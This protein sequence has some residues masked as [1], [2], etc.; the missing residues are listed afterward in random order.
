MAAPVSETELQLAFKTE[1]PD[2]QEIIAKALVLDPTEGSQLIESLNRVIHIRLWM[3]YARDVGVTRSGYA[4][5]YNL[6]STAFSRFLNMSRGNPASK[7]AISATIFRY[8][9]EPYQLR[10]VLDP[11]SGFLHVYRQIDN[12]RVSVWQNIGSR[13]IKDFLDQLI[14]VERT[15]D[16]LIA[17]DF[18]STTDEGV[19]QLLSI[20]DPGTVVIFFLHSGLMA[21][22][23]KLTQDVEVVIPMGVLLSLTNVKDA[24][25][26]EMTYRL[27]TWNQYFS[28]SVAFII[29]SRSDFIGE[30]VVRLRVDGRTIR[31]VGRPGEI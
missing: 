12:F 25:D 27:S 26:V 21:R 19:T 5:E 20:R 4:K 18:D 17:V 31:C 3:A 30:L 9:K 2:T 29:V 8:L 22:Y 23:Q 16:Q 11:V 24:A 28:I 13:I 10:P 6:D 14:N 7:K 15:C 1:S